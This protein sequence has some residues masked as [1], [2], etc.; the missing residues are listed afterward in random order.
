MEHITLTDNEFELLW[1]EAGA[2]GRGLRMAGEYPAWRQRQRRTLG[3]AASLLLAVGVALPL[4]T[5]RPTHGDFEHVYCNHR[6]IAGSQWASL[7]SELLM[8]A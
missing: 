5:A 8:E 6:G 3:A 7:A 2:R 4:L 1:H